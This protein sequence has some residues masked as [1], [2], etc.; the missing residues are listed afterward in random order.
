[1]T[2]GGNE[3]DRE[4]SNDRRRGKERMRWVRALGKTERWR[5]AHKGTDVDPPATQEGK[6]SSLHC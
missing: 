5:R 4:M 2:E 3:E 6:Y 1:M